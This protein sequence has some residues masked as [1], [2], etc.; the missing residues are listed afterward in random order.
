M[1]VT[2][3]KHGGLPLLRWACEKTMRP[4]MTSRATLRKMYQTEHSPIRT[5]M[6]AITMTGLPS[7]VSVHFVRH[8]TGVEHF[9]MTNRDDRGGEGDDKIT[10]LTPVT[11]GMWANAQAL[12]AMS[13]KRL[14][15]V[16]HP[17]TVAAMVKVRKAVRE[18]DPDLA[19]FMVPSCVYR[20]GICPEIR[21]CEQGPEAVCAAYAR[22]RAKE[23]E[24]G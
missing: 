11:H 10:R 14:C 19:H 24:R 3:E 17:K 2:V 15:L 7:F 21:P 6:F 22:L 18:V 12:M 16:S 1:Q 13:L 8:K 4:G 5:Q 9:V 23:D 20:N